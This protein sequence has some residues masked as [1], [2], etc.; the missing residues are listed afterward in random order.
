[1]PSSQPLSHLLAKYEVYTKLELERRALGSIL[2]LVQDSYARGHTKREKLDLLAGYR[3]LDRIQKHYTYSDD[4]KSKEL[5]EENDKYEIYK[6][7]R[8][9]S[10]LEDWNDLW[11]AR[12]AINE[13]VNLI[14]FW[15]ARKPWGDEVT[16]GN[17]AEKDE[18]VRDWAERVFRLAD[19][20]EPSTILADEKDF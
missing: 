11:G 14:N 18:T 16:K 4:K 8:P 5:H 20:P 7:T 6:V 3:K 1:M 17:N 2:H 9:D 13:C 15:K 10:K 12:D 19:N